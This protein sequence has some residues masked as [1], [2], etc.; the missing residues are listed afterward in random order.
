M[1]RSNPNPKIGP[2]KAQ[3]DPKRAKNQKARKQEILQNE[4]YHSTLVNLKNIFQALHKPQ[5]SQ[6]WPK[7]AHND[8][9]ISQNQKVRKQKI[10]QN[11][12]YLSA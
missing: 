5:T 1:F 12:S 10:I 3:N 2:I 11:E 8:P 9:K 6:I 7:K 4:S